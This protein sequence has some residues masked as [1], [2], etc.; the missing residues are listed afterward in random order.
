MERTTGNEAA[1]SHRR[2]Q[3]GQGGAAGRH[4][5]AAKEWADTDIVINV[6]CPAAKSASFRAVMG[7][8]PEIEATADASN[9][10]GRVGGH[11]NGS[12]R[13]PDLD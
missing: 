12:A 4:R 10:M 11:I 9:P 13:A 8:R 6:I 5:T 1:T 2:V 3:L 7:Q